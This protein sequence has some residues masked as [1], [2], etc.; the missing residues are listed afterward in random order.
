MYLKPSAKD[1]RLVALRSRARL[2]GLTVTIEFIPKLNA[3]ADERVTSGGEVKDP[4]LSVAAYKLPRGEDARDIPSIQLLRMG[5]DV[6]LPVRDVFNGWAISEGEIQS[7]TVQR[8]AF[9]HWLDSLPESI[10]GVHIDRRFVTCFWREPP[11]TQEDDVDRVSEWLKS[12][13]NL[14]E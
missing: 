14:L 6:T 8:E 12:G 4:R 2:L 11:G 5:S 3:S 7:T 9:A 10:V 1:K 13:R